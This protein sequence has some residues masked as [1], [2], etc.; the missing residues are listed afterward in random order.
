M[1]AQIE[2][3]RAAF[4]KLIIPSKKHLHFLILIFGLGFHAVLF[5]PLEIGLPDFL[6]LLLLQSDAQRNEVRI[7]KQMAESN[8]Y[9]QIKGHT[10]RKDEC[11]IQKATHCFGSKVFKFSS[12][13]EK[14]LEI[15]MR[16]VFECNGIF[17]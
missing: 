14:K 4:L 3:D 5:I 16:A 8:P 1:S 17:H 15:R 2:N 9:S 10:I 11:E 7:V 13:Y 12:I 6:F